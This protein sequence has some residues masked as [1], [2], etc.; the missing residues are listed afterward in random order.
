LQNKILPTLISV[1]RLTHQKGFDVLLAAF[2]Q[3]ETSVP[4][5]LIIFGEGEDR[6]ALESQIKQLDLQ[7]KVSLPGYTHN[8]IAEMQ[9]ADLYVLS[10][11]FEGSP[12][13]LV[14]AMSVK[15]PVVAFDIPHGPKEILHNGEVACLVKNISEFALADAI[16]QA[17]NISTK[18]KIAQINRQQKAI[19]CFFA[20]NSAQH[21]RSLILRDSR[22]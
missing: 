10:S 6:S 2:H 5:R 9:A 1:G 17:L 7:N 19:E 20:A 16:K 15:T 3:V 14:E 13:A 21:Y 12:N 4:C 8:P 18:Q 22:L 11:R